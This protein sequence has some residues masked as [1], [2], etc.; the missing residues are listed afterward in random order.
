[1]CVTAI[2]ITLITL[3]KLKFVL[4]FFKTYITDYKKRISKK[5][6]KKWSNTK[7][8]SLDIN[9]CK[10]EDFVG[11]ELLENSIENKRFE[12]ECKDNLRRLQRKYVHVIENLERILTQ[13]RGECEN[14][15]ADWEQDHKMYETLENS[16]SESH[17]K[18]KSKTMIDLLQE[19]RLKY[20][21]EIL[22]MEEFL[23]EKLSEREALRALTNVICENI[24]NKRN[25]ENNHTLK[26]QVV[27]TVAK[28]NFKFQDD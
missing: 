24:K 18:N 7:G 26:E 19:S 17:L 13:M 15:N 6:E 25:L 1:M 28:N 12:I 23:T 8:N 9:D 20:A 16:N 11:P 22:N 14:I 21:N 2:N 10:T 3:I 27:E 5:L 4:R